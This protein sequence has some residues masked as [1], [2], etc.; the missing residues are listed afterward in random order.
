MPEIEIRFVSHDEYERLRT[1][2]DKY[3]VTWRGMLIHG[4]TR[5]ESRDVP[6]PLAHFSRDACTPSYEKRS[7]RPDPD[8]TETSTDGG[9]SDDN[10]HEGAL[11]QP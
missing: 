6:R 9:G 2:K 8:T 7:S 5:L 3:G 10:E 11:E 4:A 1:I